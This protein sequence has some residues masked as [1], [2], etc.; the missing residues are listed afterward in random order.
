MMDTSL[1]STRPPQAVINA[2]G[3]EQEIRVFEAWKTKEDNDLHPTLRDRAQYDRQRAVWKGI[4]TEYV[5]L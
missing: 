2:M 4:P 5:L 3:E 1:I